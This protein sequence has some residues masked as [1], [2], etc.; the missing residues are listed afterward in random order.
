MLSRGGHDGILGQ[1]K[2]QGG[3]LP[4]PGLELGEGL[5]AKGHEDV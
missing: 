1:A 5:A 3:P 4:F 2:L